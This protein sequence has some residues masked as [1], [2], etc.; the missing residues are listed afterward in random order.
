[1]N[2]EEVNLVSV[3]SMTPSDESRKK[4]GRVLSTG[5]WHT[6]QGSVLQLLTQPSQY[7]EGDPGVLLFTFHKPDS[8]AR[9]K[10]QAGIWNYLSETHFEDVER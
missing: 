4:R 5:P 9:H 3:I 2:F 1:M 8:R 10:I 6:D 7:W